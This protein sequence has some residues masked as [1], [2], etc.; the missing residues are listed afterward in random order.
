MTLHMYAKHKEWDLQKVNVHIS[1]SK[2]EVEEGT[3]QDVFT[4]HIEIQGELDKK[5][6][7]RLIEIA[8]KCPVHKTLTQGS[9]VIT[10]E[11]ECL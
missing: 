5:Q 10:L 6:R 11:K 2:E 3:K 4:R 8:N 1:H 7:K 9:K